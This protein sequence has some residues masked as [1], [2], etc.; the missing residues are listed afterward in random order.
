MAGAAPALDRTLR[1]VPARPPERAVISTVTGAPFAGEIAELL[2]RQLTSPVLFSDAVRAAGDVDLF[3]E[4]GPG[5][6]LA[7]LVA[8]SGVPVVAVDACGRS[9]RGLLA[10]LGA[11]WTLGA[12]VDLAALF[13]DRGCKPVDLLRGPRLLANPCEDAPAP[14]A[15][16]P[17][18]I[19]IEPAI[20]PAIERAIE[21]GPAS[22]SRTV[23]SSDLLA[24]LR[25][26]IAEATE[27]PPGS[28]AEGTR[29]LE[30]IHLSSISIGQIVTRVARELGLPAPRPLTGWA[31]A[32]LAEIAAAFADEA[33]PH[34]PAP[35]ASPPAASWVRAFATVDIAASPPAAPRP[36]RG[37][38]RWY[39]A[40]SGAGLPSDLLD[41]TAAGTAI[42]ASETEL[43]A[44]VDG[45]RAGGPFLVIDPQRIAGGFARTLHLE[46][47]QPVTVVAFDDPAAA[48]TH[49]AIRA[50]AA[51]LTA[52]FR[53]VH[54]GP[55]GALTTP[56]LAAAPLA[57]PDLA[58]GPDDVV[59]VTGGGKGIAAEC[60]LALARRS[61]CGLVTISRRAPSADPEL[62]ANL[63]RFA[64]YG[65]RVVHVVADVT[66]A[67]ALRVG[68][69]SA[70]DALGPATAILH[71]AAVNQPRALRDLTAAELR[72]T[73]APKLRGLHN[74]L[75]CV[76][77]ARLRAVVS[78]GS[79]IARTG[80]PGEAHYALANDLLRRATLAL[81][82]EL[83]ACRCAVLEWSAWAEVG[84]AERIGRL[85]AL[86]Q[87]GLSPISIDHGV[88]MCLR[89][90]GA[91][92]AIA[93]TGR[94]GDAG[95][96]A[97]RPRA[98]PLSRFIER[99]LVHVPEVELVSEVELSASV[100]RYLDDHV[101]EGARVMPAVLQIEAAHQVVAA[102]AQP[103]ARW[104]IAALQFPRAILVDDEGARIRIAA[105]V[106]DGGRAEVVITAST[107]GHRAECMRM[108]L[109]PDAAPPRSRAGAS[110]DGGG[111]A[112]P[113]GELLP[114][115]GRFARITGYQ[116][117]ETRRCRFSVRTAGDADPWFAHHVS[118]TLCLADPG[119]RDAMLHGMQVAVPHH[120]LV[121]VAA[122]DV[123]LAAHWPRGEVVVE[124]RELAGKDGE[125]TWTLVARDT[126]GVELERWSE[127]TF[128]SL[129]ERQTIPALVLRPWLE[130]CL[131][132]LAPI[133]Q[134]AALDA[135]GAAE[136]L[137]GVRHR[138]D[139]RPETRDGGISTSIGA[140]LRLA[141]T[142]PDAVA[143]DLE[144]IEARPIGVW[145]DLLGDHA[146]LAAELAR[147]SGE[148]FDHAATRVWVALECVAKLGHPAPHLLLVSAA[149]A[150]ASLRA[151]TIEVLTLAVQILGQGGIA[152]GVAT[153]AAPMMAGI[154]AAS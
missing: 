56:A 36:G 98:L 6:M 13:A 54:V 47:G 108:T 34:Q 153:A 11:A 77:R 46:T 4:L 41:G 1:A 101:L 32:T 51:G 93:I 134:I 9:L 129:G 63:E 103:H 53:D 60:A 121:P 3:V 79:I 21:P 67:A 116:Q 33:R 97:F 27:L 30:D 146:E 75:A 35:A 5:R 14:A 154:E 117:L 142:G 43:D 150:A 125:Y 100:D 52:G 62:A 71:A 126:H 29:L 92:G 139:H 88:R 141:V 137:P 147:Q 115:R 76:D 69:A 122:R 111:L 109:E 38:W 66:D 105:C 40:A 94:L 19:A 106:L 25:R 73:I 113:Y 84:M 15:G 89:G 86:I 99:P 45:A 127:V 152:I 10:A 85:D 112:A 12:P 17:L 70:C 23:R 90:F 80:L 91:R 120:R 130:R 68:L 55:G 107:D 128:R 57:E 39:G 131:G 151:G 148:P 49:A 16:A 50:E 124:A 2:V 7:T 149:G 81:S 145:R 74:V 72:H 135:A 133:V 82:H 140:G 143:C 59:I 22:G 42:V 31:R 20:E 87:R 28:I 102:L 110:V 132:E 64:A 119:V 95:I 123:H 96:A 48:A 104:R 26:A 144:A 118:A 8:G 37:A 78:F 138:P 44:L 136:P 114:Q 83:P 61:G 65:V 58:L 18:P 24:R